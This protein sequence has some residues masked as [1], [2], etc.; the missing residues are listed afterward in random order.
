MGKYT[1]EMVI[2]FILLGIL[3]VVLFGYFVYGT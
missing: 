1:D 3:L 2:A